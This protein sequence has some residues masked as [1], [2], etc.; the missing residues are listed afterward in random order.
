LEEKSQT[1]KEI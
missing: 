1:Y